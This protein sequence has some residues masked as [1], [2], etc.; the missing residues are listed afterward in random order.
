ML[1]RLCLATGVAMTA[2]VAV[3]WCAGPRLVDVGRELRGSAGARAHW[4]LA[5]VVASGLAIA[6]VGAYVVLTVTALI[7]IASHLV[8]PKHAAAV[9]ARGWAGPRWWRTIVLTACGVGIATQ[10]VA[11]SAAGVPD[12]P[13]CASVCAPRLDGLPYPDLPTGS[14][15]P[16]PSIAR[17]ADDARQDLQ[18]PERLVVR[19]GD[20]LWAIAVDLSP[21]HASPAHIAELAHRLYAVN[22]DLIGDDPDL[23]YPETLLRAP[24]GPHDRRA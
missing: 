22:R 18:P 24:G 3:C 20:S 21:P 14:W 9:V 8:A 2:G 16:T 19:E 7:A 4:T 1:L 11:T 13:P 12:S 6:A 23:I 5:D 17:D 10:A 15:A